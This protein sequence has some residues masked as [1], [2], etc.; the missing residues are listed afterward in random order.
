MA[1]RVQ[2]WPKAAQEKKDETKELARD[3]IELVESARKII[4][5]N[6]LEC[7][8]MLSDIYGDAMRILWLM[9]E[10]DKLGG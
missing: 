9:S 5:S 1:T 7:K 3:I 2:P 6:P 10:A 8:L 4:V